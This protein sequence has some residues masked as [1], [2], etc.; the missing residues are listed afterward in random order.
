MNISNDLNLGDSLLICELA[1][2]CK[3]F[4]H[5]DD[6]G[7]DSG[8]NLEGSDDQLHIKLGQ[9]MPTLWMLG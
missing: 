6:T 2:T 3:L 5:A 9:L 8:L 7:P 1:Q 4:V